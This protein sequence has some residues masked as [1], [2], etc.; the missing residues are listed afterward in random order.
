LKGL[1][2]SLPTTGAIPLTV[3]LGQVAAFKVGEGPNQVSRENGKPE[4]W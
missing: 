2:V 1:P 3:P 4:S